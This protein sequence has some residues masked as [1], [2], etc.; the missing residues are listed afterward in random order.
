MA[1]GFF[2]Q[3][4]G[5]GQEWETHGGP[6]VEVLVLQ[7]KQRGHAFAKPR[8]QQ[9]QHGCRVTGRIGFSRA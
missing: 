7:D 8:Q 5:E 6:S 1:G 9:Q 3:V 2:P 4:L